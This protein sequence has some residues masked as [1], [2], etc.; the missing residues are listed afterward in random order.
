MREFRHSWGTL[1]GEQNRIYLLNFQQVTYKTTTITQ[2]MKIK[3]MR[4]QTFAVN[5]SGVSLIQVLVLNSYM[6]SQAVDR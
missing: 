5:K 3:A 1:A 6:F 2:L 4:Y